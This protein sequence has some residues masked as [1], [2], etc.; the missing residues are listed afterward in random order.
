MNWRELLAQELQYRNPSEDICTEKYSTLLKE[1]IRPTLADIKEELN[2]YVI[3]SDIEGCELKVEY[4]FSGYWFKFKIE[5]SENCK[6]K[7]SAFYVDKNDP[8]LEPGSQ[9][10]LINGYNKEVEI[11]LINPDQIGETFYE[12]FKPMI[13]DFYKSGK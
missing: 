13:E 6:V 9:P 10:K 2:K 1:V 4:G 8:D 3:D 7:F 5:K 12:A 11:E